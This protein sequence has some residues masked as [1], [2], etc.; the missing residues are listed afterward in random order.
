MNIILT[1]P[2][3]IKEIV[4]RAVKEAL[5][6]ILPN[7]IRQASKKEWLKTDEV[8]DYLQCTRR[9]IQYLRDSEQLPYS[10]NG[11]TIRYHIDDIDTF[12]KTHK[13]KGR[14]FRNR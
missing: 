6:D 1:T 3:E 4:N 11:R 10:Q 2:E 5:R 9:H 14:L 8:M 7:V 12:L 13:T